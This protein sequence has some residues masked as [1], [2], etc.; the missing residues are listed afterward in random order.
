MF[1]NLKGAC[2]K[3]LIKNLKG[4]HRGVINISQKKIINKKS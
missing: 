4:G 2:E 1:G 3:K